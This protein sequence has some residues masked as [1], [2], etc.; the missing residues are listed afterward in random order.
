MQKRRGGGDKGR[1]EG[2]ERTERSGER[3]KNPGGGHERCTNIEWS[4]SK[5]EE[6]K[7]GL[8]RSKR[9]KENQTLLFYRKFW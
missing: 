6:K 5:Q 8:E 1:K 2:V 9:R 4:C 7:E 3:E